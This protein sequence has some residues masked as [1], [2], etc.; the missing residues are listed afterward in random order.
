MRSHRWSLLLLL[1]SS[2]VTLFATGGSAAADE[3]F[4]E[5][6]G[7]G[8]SGAGGCLQA[9]PCSIQSAIED[10]SV[11]NGDV[12]TVLP[13]TYETQASSLFINDDITVRGLETSPMPVIPAGAGANDAVDVANN[14][15][16]LR[17]L[18]I[19]INQPSTDGLQSLAFSGLLAE[20]IQ[21]ENSGNSGNACNLASTDATIRDSVCWGNGSSS[22]LVA[23]S[24][25]GTQTVTARNL[26]AFS[27]TGT[28]IE[29]AGSGTGNI[30][31]NAKNVI[32]RGGPNPFDDVAASTDATSFATVTLTNS[33]Y[34]R[35]DATGAGATIT[36]SNTNN[37]QEAAPVFANAAGGDFH[38]QSTSP[39]RNAGT[40][41]AG[42]DSIGTLDID[43]Q[44]RTEEGVIDIGA[45]EF[46]PTGNGG[47]GDPSPGPEPVADGPPD[48]T[49]TQ[50]P[51]GRTKKK[52]A[53][54]SFSGNDARTIAR[55]ECRLDN[56]AFETCTSPKTYSGLK[57]GEH[58]VQVRAVDDAGQ[59][60]PTP[61]TATWTVK[62]KKKKKK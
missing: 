61:A 44:P 49:I 37:N 48:T 22:G 34:V 33:N 51:S 58:T 24:S 11:A 17:W 7:N 16:E 9:D 39:T 60:D 36:P 28:A 56:G 20:R 18:R 52:S 40:G 8:A 41:T 55:F 10:A 26:T 13:G 35:E 53:T 2:V 23:S 5:P 14:N 38:Q 57:K 46:I 29:A 42:S 43:A 59:A 62:K 30:T 6:N 3:R 19:Q 50:A 32:A 21:V 4:A 25:A 27:V 31:I 45:D 1:S 47:G 15:V 54:I 12:V